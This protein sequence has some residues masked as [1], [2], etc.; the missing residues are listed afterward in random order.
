MRTQDVQQAMY[1]AMKARHQDEAAA[2]RLILSALRSAEID[3]RKD[4]DD[5]EVT[6]VLAR[7][8][9]RRKEAEVAFREAGRT[10]RADQEAYELEVIARFLPAP[11]DSAELA[12]LVDAA[13]AE[14]GASAPG[15]LGRVMGA[16]MP[17]VKGRADGAEIRRLVQAR[18]TGG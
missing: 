11:M 16:L 10:D 12:S 2:I 13:V 15:D 8:A 17:K 5:D 1:A 9:K 18:L 14:T 6:A 3:A 4:L 7:E